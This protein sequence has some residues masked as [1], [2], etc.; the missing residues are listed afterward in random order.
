MDS[1]GFCGGKRCRNVSGGVRVKGTEAV[2][3]SEKMAGQIRKWIKYKDRYRKSMAHAKGRITTEN[4]N[5]GVS[6]YRNIVRWHFR[7]E[8][9]LCSL[10]A[11]K[12]RANE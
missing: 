2:F 1:G 10:F 11:G 9:L 6:C 8:K 7:L 4:G 3:F 12:I 5:A